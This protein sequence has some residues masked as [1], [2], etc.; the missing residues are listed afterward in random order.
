[1]FLGE[2]YVVSLIGNVTTAIH[3]NTV[4]SVKARCMKK[5]KKQARETDPDR[6]ILYAVARARAAVGAREQVATAKA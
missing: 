1:M 4:Q 3:C 2:T 6:D 5:A